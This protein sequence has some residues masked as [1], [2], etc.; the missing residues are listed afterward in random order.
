M[1]ATFLGHASWL[2]EEGEARLLID[3]WLD[4][5]PQAPVKAADLHPNYILV[6]HG[7][8]DHDA[9]AVAIARANDALIITTNE[10]ANKYAEEGART[11]GMHIGGTFDFDFGP[12]RVTPAFHGSGVA[13]GHAAGFI[14]GLG[15]K[16]VYHAGDTSLFGDM[17]LL[18]RLESIDLAF[19]PI[20]GNFTMPLGDAVLA[21]EMLRPKQVVPMHYNTFPVIQADPEEFRR[22]V[23]QRTDT[24][25][26]VLKPGESL[27]L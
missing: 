1:K 8:G 6:T 17:E 12:V 10:L 5:N 14:V 25:V 21:V 15:G 11:H 4:G 19:L 27:E 20:G 26:S 3:P 13:G 16:K 18:G 9:D 2:L 7:H 22:R 24:R 23:E